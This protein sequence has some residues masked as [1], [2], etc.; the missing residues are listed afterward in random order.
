MDAPTPLW[1]R[2]HEQVKGLF[3]DL[4]AH[5]QNTFA[6]FVLGIAPGLLFGVLVGLAPWTAN[7]PTHT[8]LHVPGT[9]SLPTPG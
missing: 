5:Q 7:A 8:G 2:W 4:H 3:P 6:V 1:S 9:G